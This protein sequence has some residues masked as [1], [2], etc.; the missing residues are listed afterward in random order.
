MIVPHF[1]AFRRVRVDRAMKLMFAAAMCAMSVTISPAQ[2]F[3][4]TVA[5]FGTNTGGLFYAPMQANNGNLYGT[6]FQGGTGAGCPYSTGCGTIYQLTAAGGLSTLY[7]FCSQPNCTDGEAP[8]GGLA[9][10]PN[11]NLYGTTTIGG[12]YGFGRVFEI[13][14]EGALT[15]LYS[16]CPAGG[17][18]SDGAQPRAGLLLGSDGNFYGTTEYGGPSPC[19]PVATCGTV[20]QITP[21]VC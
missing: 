16:F 14:P 4:N 13:T 19:G 10:G 7:D 1:F 5:T 12:T 15:T 18:C 9:Q 20:F 3:F 17:D 21:G 6:T 11:G 2:M 8:Y